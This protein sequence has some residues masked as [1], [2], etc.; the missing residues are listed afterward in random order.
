MRRNVIA[1]GA[2]AYL[3]A[4]IVVMM[5]THRKASAYES[6]F[7]TWFWWVPGVRWGSLWSWL[8]VAWPIWLPAS[9]FLPDIS[10]S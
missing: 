6:Q 9:Y 4:G 5:F 2:I 8:F 3:I 1:V 7:H 10:D